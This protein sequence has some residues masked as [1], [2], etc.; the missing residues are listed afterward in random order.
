MAR[1]HRIEY[2][3]ACYHVINRG[4]Y[5]AWVFADEGAKD[6]FE[7]CSAEA[8][9]ASISTLERINSAPWID[10]TVELRPR[11][12]QNGPGWTAVIW[13]SEAPEYRGA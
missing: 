8:A 12:G 10:S 1:R 6:V 3:G 2:A 11:G 9:P 13:F 4:N 7:L 5:R